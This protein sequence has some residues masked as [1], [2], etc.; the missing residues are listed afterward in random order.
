[1]LEDLSQLVR[2]HLS[3]EDPI[4]YETAEAVRDGR[5]G[6]SAAASLAAF[7]ALKEDWGQYLY[8]WDPEHVAR[9]WERFRDESVVMLERLNERVAAE[10]AVLY[11][12][13]IHHQVLKPGVSRPEPF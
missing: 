8:R 10:T 11:S 12:L 2:N 6:G 3:H 13:A 7:E 5:H 9:D 1:M 4:V